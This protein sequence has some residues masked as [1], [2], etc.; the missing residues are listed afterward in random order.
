MVIIMHFNHTDA[1]FVNAKI[2]HEH[3]CTCNIPLWL[4]T[5]V[6]MVC[7]HAIY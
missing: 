3:N 6:K 1:H 5:S 2:L 7:L 4:T